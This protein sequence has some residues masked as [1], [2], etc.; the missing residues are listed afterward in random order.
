MMNRFPLKSCDWLPALLVAACLGALQGASGCGRAESP[1]IDSETHWLTICDGDEDCGA[2][3]CEC[4]VCTQPCATSADCAGLGLAGVECLPLSDAC[5]SAA[6]EPASDGAA[7]LLTCADDGDCAALGAGARCESQRCERIE[8]A[9]LDGIGGSSG[10]DGSGVAGVGQA[11]SGGQ[12][13]G[14][15]ASAGAALC[16]GSEDI[17]FVYFVGGGFVSTYYSFTA[18]RGLG[19]LAI[20]G[21]CQFWRSTEPGGVVSAGTLDPEDAETFASTLDYERV[22]AARDYE[23]P[24]S[25]T[26]GGT[27]V[28]WTPDSRMT[29]SC[30]PCSDN[31]N[32]P[33]GWTIAF[34][35]MSDARL[36]DWFGSGQPMTGPARMVLL[37]LQDS[38]SEPNPL[39]PWPLSR[40]PRDN[41]WHLAPA[42][43]DESSGVEL[44]D[45][46]E[47]SLLRATRAT[48][49]ERV[50]GSDHTQIAHSTPSSI[51]AFD[52]LLRDELP[53]PVQAALRVASGVP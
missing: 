17:R 53:A 32:A 27:R 29:C 49:L 6:S 40:E 13:G 23:D 12:A 39:L 48:Y 50:P 37:I 42:S 43:L 21:Q 33:S 11:G 5:A 15:S 28:V 14:S 45:P 34:R 3:S 35:T 41:E 51:G 9:S 25:C 2:G 10:S 20:D 26:D 16:D 8:L 1:Q 44:T 24:P 4:G 30:G 47:L 31:P 19:F 46:D 38:A 22:L 7:C 18:S 52:M 36:N